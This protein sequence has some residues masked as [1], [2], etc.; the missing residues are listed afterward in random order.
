MF[1]SLFAKLTIA[2]LII[3]CLL[4]LLFVSVTLFSTNLYQQ[5]VMQKLNREIAE[6]IVKDT[7]ILQNGKLNQ[8][9]LK[10]LFHTLM[11]FNPSLEIYL[12]DYEGDIMAFS[13]APWKVVRTSVD[14][15]PIKKYLEHG[16]QFPLQGDDPRDL[17]K[18]KI[19]SVAV[20]EYSDQFRGYLYVILGG[21]EYDDI[22]ARV[23]GSYILKLSLLIIIVGLVFSAIA[24]IGLLATTTRRLNKLSRAMEKFKQRPNVGSE[25]LTINRGNGDEIDHLTE[26]FQSMAEKIVCQLDNLQTTDQL[27]RE[28]VANVSHD[29]RT[30]LATLQGYIETLLIK[31][32]QLDT[33]QRQQ[34]LQVAI[35][36]CCRLNKLVEEL[37]ELA[38]LDAK[39]TRARKEPFNLA[40]LIQDISQKFLLKASEKNINIKIKKSIATA[41]VI[42]DIS[43]IERVIENLLENAL[44]HTPVNGLIYIDL[45][46]EGNVLNVQVRDSGHG[47]PE[48]EIPYIFDRFYQIDKTRNN[49]DNGTGLGL[50]I[51]KRIIEL[52]QSVIKVS[53]DIDGFTCFRFSLPMPAV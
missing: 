37:F 15:A 2:L 33:E 27:R 34:Y 32:Q 28:L 50:A 52:H 49:D 51:V 17:N 16:Q 43:L 26:T 40:E 46:A 36:H 9:A 11:V 13:A 18:S 12:L 25:K 22:M 4:G 19:F 35:K 38:K 3:F 29:L 45:Q 8:L 41:F 31:D 1:N 30:P 6:H 23:Q 20:V 10:K 24:G 5:E 42:A 7:E 53:S 21:E 39:E 14:L 44:R 48:H 47:I